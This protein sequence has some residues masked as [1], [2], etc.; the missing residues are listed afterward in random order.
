MKSKRKNFERL[1]NRHL[2]AADVI[3]GHDLE[4]Y[5]TNEDQQLVI[6]APGILANDS[7]IDCEG[8]LSAQ[9]KMGPAKGEVSVGADGSFVYTP[10]PNFSGLDS[11]IYEVS[12]DDDSDLGLVT[13]RVHPINDAPLA[14]DDEA[15][16]NEDTLI[17]GNVLDNDSDVDG[18]ALTTSLVDDPMNGSVVLNDDGSFEYTPN[19][20]FHGDDSFTYVAHDGLADSEVATVNITVDSVND[21][22]TAVADEAS[23]DEDTVISGNVLDNDSDVDG[24]M[25]TA[26]LVED[27]MNGSVVLNDDGSFEY[28]P[29]PD[30]HGADSFTYVS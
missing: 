6:E 11:F 1:E 8:P 29:N 27:P 5:S 18:D 4:I 24:D 23:G 26:S 22:P 17:S 2:L 28:T 7:C 9:L 19:P 30:F 13:V 21:A 3:A 16:G 14:A 15:S 25:L 12:A 20:E 10:D